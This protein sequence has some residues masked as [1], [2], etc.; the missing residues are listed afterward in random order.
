VRPESARD[1]SRRRGASGRRLPERLAA[2]GGPGCVRRRVRSYSHRDVQANGSGLSLGQAEVPRGRLSEKGQRLMCLASPAGSSLEISQTG[3]MRW[4]ARTSGGTGRKVC[5]E[6]LPRG[7]NRRLT[8]SSR[9]DSPSSKGDPRKP[10]GR[11]RVSED[12]RPARRDP[13]ARGGACK[14]STSIA[15]GRVPTRCGRGSRAAPAAWDV[16]EVAEGRRIDR[17]A[18]HRTGWARRA[19]ARARAPAARCA[20][21]S[22][23]DRQAHADSPARRRDLPAFGTLLARAGLSPQTPVRLKSAAPV[24]IVYAAASKPSASRRTVPAER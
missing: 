11:N 12:L 13:G 6:H 14:T 10:S 17:Q 21:A 24:R 15:D 19:G 8:S 2:R 1:G 5:L 22:R 7:R 4:G 3:G 20:S 23:A 9:R 16:L 18:R